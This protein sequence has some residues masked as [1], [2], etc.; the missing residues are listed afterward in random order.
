MIDCFHGILALAEVVWT[1]PAERN[2]EEFRQRVQKHYDR[3]NALMLIMDW[4]QNHLRS[5][6]NMIQLNNDFN[7][8]IRQLQNDLILNLK[9][10]EIS[11][12]ILKDDSTNYFKVS[13]LE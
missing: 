7:V 10:D 6:K 2:Y 5:K 11:H 3:L 1:Y 12:T 8:K 4:K 9:G 13:N